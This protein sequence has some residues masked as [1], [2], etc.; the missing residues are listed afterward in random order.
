MTRIVS[1]ARP[2]LSVE[3]NQRRGVLAALAS[4]SLVAVVAGCAN[5]GAVTLQQPQQDSQPVIVTSGTTPTTPIEV[6]VPSTIPRTTTTTTTVAPTT[7]TTIATTTT[8]A[9]DPYLVTP[10]MFPIQTLRKGDSGERVADLQNRL[11]QLGFW[12]DAADGHYGLATSQAVMAFQK[13][14]NVSDKSGRVD[15]ATADA[16]NTVPSK[17]RPHATEGDLI[18][19]NKAA[20]VL[21]II[22][23]GQAVWTLNVSTGSGNAYTETSKKEPG[24]ILKGDAQT[25]DGLYQVNRERAEG[26]WE[27]ELGELYR[28]KYFRGGIAVHGS[29]NI[30]NYPASHGCVR[31]STPA[32][33]FI[34]AANLMPLGMPV[35]VHS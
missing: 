16:L 27:G 7:S 33:D 9:P 15:Q 17:A 6:T 19:V 1:D 25:P 35:W 12:V 13:Y 5:S 34:W 18:E 24:R 20:Q 4:V 29:N 11:L 8:A 21:H 28:P 22:R 26:W 14:F 31:V 2:V 3:P 32:M 30:P 23:G 10:P